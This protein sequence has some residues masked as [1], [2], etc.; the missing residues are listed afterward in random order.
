MK[1][2][3]PKL[4]NQILI[5]LILGS[6]FGALFNIN[7]NLLLIE[8]GAG[9][10]INSIAVEDWKEISFV[11]VGQTEKISFNSAQQQQ[12]LSKYDEIVSKKQNFIL[13]INSAKIDG[14]IKTEYTISEVTSIRRER[15]LPGKIKWIGDIFI[16]LL[17]MIAVPLVLASLLVGAASLGD[18]KKFARIGSKTIALYLITTAFAITIGLV[19][20]NVIQP[21]KQMNSATKEN[22]MVSYQ[23]E[24]AKKTVSKLEIGDENFFVNI[25]PKNPFDALST[26]NMLQ[27]VFFSLLLGM[28][29]TMIDQS[30]AQPVIA[31]FEGLSEAMIKLVD[32]V[33]LIAPIGVFALIGAVVSEFGFEILQT[34]IWYAL[35][36]IL[37]L[38]IHTLG[39]YA[40]L[41]NFVAKLKV[42]DFFK[43]IRRAQIVAFST[44]SSA[45]TLPVTMECA[46]ENLGVSK[47]ISSFVLPLGATVNM[48]GTALY[49]GVAAVFIAQVFGI[50]LN[51]TQQVT[52]VLMATLASIGTA[53][54]P[55][56][57]II[58]LVI[59]LKTV[60]IPEEG[61]AL[62]LGVDRILDM[63]RT[64]TNISGDAVVASVVAKSE[65]EKL[66][67]NLSNA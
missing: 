31:F 28:I 11:V 45:A 14:S 20:A 42:V 60:G 50:E 65:G 62:I 33:M 1:L 39:T 26:A 32:I 46:E 48:D 58:M 7:K 64:V 54:V 15:T 13:V 19:A 51:L 61:I 3:L 6:L 44:S 35:A 30:K 34:L 43:A 8:Y 57:G 41:I 18:I 23:E 47:S 2:R 21:G 17:N 29:L 67:I 49:Q 55:G 52:I 10:D 25:V 9:K 36:V 38:L 53:P 16:R 59:I 27:I 40:T 24:A 12:I 66:N 5:A 4:H 22:L 63:C 56:V 37:G